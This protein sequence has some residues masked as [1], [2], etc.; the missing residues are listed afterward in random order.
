MCRCGCWGWSFIVVLELNVGWNFD[1]LPELGKHGSPWRWDPSLGTKWAALSVSTKSI[2]R[3]RIWGQKRPGNLTTKLTAAKKKKGSNNNCKAFGF[4]CRAAVRKAGLVYSKIKLL[5][6]CVILQCSCE[7]QFI[8]HKQPI[9]RLCT[10]GSKLLP[11]CAISLV[12][13]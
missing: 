10:G 9:L 5:L 12:Q 13:V 2:P 1:L 8:S 11:Y 6:Y 7:G 3:G 4:P